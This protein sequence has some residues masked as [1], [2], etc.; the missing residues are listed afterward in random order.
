[1]I[2]AYEQDVTERYFLFSQGSNGADKNEFISQFT[3]LQP[4]LFVDHKRWNG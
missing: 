3:C 4:S 1:M 2:L